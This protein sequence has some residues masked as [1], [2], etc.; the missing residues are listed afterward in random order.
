MVERAAFR[1]RRADPAD[2]PLLAQPLGRP[3]GELQQQRDLRAVVE[4]VGDDGEC[5]LVEDRE[6]LVVAQTETSLKGC[7]SQNSWFSPP[8]T[9]LTESSVK[10]RR[11]ES[12]RRSA[13]LSTCLLYTSPSP[14][15]S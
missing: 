8:K 10:I 13:Q 7:G 4:V 5:V 14:R 11:I 6:Q 9:S 12:V 3:G 15:D 2:E 1:A